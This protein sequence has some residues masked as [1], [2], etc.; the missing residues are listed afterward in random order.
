M[1]SAIPMLLLTAGLAGLSALAGCSSGDGAADAGA[2]DTGSGPPDTGVFA[3]A[4]P[5]DMGPPPCNRDQDCASGE[6]CNLR[7]RQCAPG[8]ACTSQTDCDRCSALA[9]PADCGHGFTVNAYCDPGRGNVCTRSLSPCEP[10]QD[11]E[12]CGP[13]HPTIRGSAQPSKCLDYGNGEKFC[14]RDGAFGCPVGFTRDAA[15]NQCKRDNN[16]GC[17]PNVT[18]CPA[19]PAGDM[20]CPTNAGQICA[21]ERCPNASERCSAN[22]LPGGTGVCIGACQNNDDCTDPNFPVCN[23]RTGTCVQGCTKDSCAA[24]QVCHANGFCG[25]PCT[26]DQACV[27][28]FQDQD[29]YCNLDNRFAAPRSY[30]DYRDTNACAPLGCEQAR[31]CGGAG[32]VCDLRQDPPACVSGCYN[33]RDC[34]AGSVCK[35][36]GPAGPQPS[37]DRAACRALAPKPDNRDIGICCNPGCTNRVT[38]C[39]L[40]QFCCAEPGSPYADSATCGAVTST[41]T[42]QSRQAEP[43]EC[44]FLEAPPKSPFCSFCDPMMAGGCNSDDYD[45]QGSAWTAG[46]NQDPAINGGQPF[47]EQELCIPFAETQQGVVGMCAVSCNPNST[48]PGRGCPRGWSCGRVYPGCLQD[49]DCNGLTCV[50]A[51]TSVDP[52]REGRC[53]CGEGGTVSAQCPTAYVRFGEAVQNPR[54]VLDQA[55]QMM[56]MFCLATYV[57][58]PTPLRENPPMSGNFNY[59]AACLNTLP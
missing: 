22:D 50:G 15:T 16:V 54:C 6:V 57:C 51:D 13:L 17:P 9:N 49:A 34:A 1:R 45:R 31:D 26:D 46:Y 47:K 43:G 10:C 42:M 32:R 58:R 37:Y 12:D 11:D 44:F 24:G 52:P 14:G 19:R 56:R 33:D 23:P 53:Q 28:R 59:P 5:V 18:P 29:L 55:D 21:G 48:D 2:T 39:D 4:E 7:T 20:A 30:K 8:T 40:N 36:P 25:M 3:D 41:A 27:D 38:Q 35:D